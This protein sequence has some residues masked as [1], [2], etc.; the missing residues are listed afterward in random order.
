MADAPQ[1]DRF[2]KTVYQV[3]DPGEVRDMYDRWAA[4]YDIE[5]IEENG[6]AQ[7]R[8]CAE[9]LSRYLTNRR[10]EI[11]DIG[12][13]TGLS[14]AA[15][16]DAGYGVIDG[17]DFS[18]GMLEKA[19]GTGFYRR[20]FGADLNAP[21]LDATDAAY[22]AAVAVVVDGVRRER[23]VAHAEVGGAARR[24]LLR[25]GERQADLAD[26]RVDVLAHGTTGRRTSAWARCAAR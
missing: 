11:L 7:P 20:L 6:Y 3:H 17:C 1:N 12:C 22:D 9:M 8:R 18:A 14:G 4:S 21:P 25:F 23:L 26:R 13:G 5:L 16:A 19:R 15:L 2:L 10:A 24:P